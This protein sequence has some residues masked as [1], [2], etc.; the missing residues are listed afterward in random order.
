MREKRKMPGVPEAGVFLVILASVLYV[1]LLAGGNPEAFLIDDNRTQWYPVMERAY[2]DLW[3]AGRIYCYD[4]YQMKGMSVAGQGYYGIMNPFI[5]LSYSVTK[6]LPEGIDAI[7]FYI[8]MMVVLGNLFLYLVCRRLG[9]KE[10]AALLLTLAYS[11]MGC[12]WA[13]YIWYYVFNNYFLVPLLVYVFLRCRQE[14]R[15]SYC[16]CGVVL[17]MDLWMGNVQYTFYHYILF[18]ILCLTMAAL[19]NRCYFKILCINTTV[20]IVLSLPM[21]L[22]LLQTSGGFQKHEDFMSYPLLY[23]S[24]LIH[25][26]IPQGILRCRGGGVNFL[27]AFVM[28][29]DDN[30]VCYMGIVGILLATALFRAVVRLLKRAGESGQPRELWEA[31]RTGYERAVLWTHEKKTAAGCAAA[32]LFFLSLMSGGAAAHCLS[33]MPVVRNFRYLF[34]A[35]FPAMPLAVLMLAHIIGRD[36]RK[37]RLRSATTLFVLAAVYA[38]VGVLNACDTVKFVRHLYDMRLEKDFAGEKEAAF[39]ALAAADV[40][41]KNYRTAAFLRFSGL[42]DECFDMSRNLTRNFPTAVGV[43]SL[44][45]YEIATEE[46]RLGM[47]DAIYSETEFLTRYAN[48]DTLENFNLNLLREP[49]KVQRQLVENSVRY[50]FLDKTTLAENRLAQER[51]DCRFQ[52]DRREEVIAALRALPDIRV[53][54]IRPFNEHYDLAELAGTASLCMDKAGHKV[55]LTDE[56]MQTLSFDAQAAQDYTLSFAWDRH[57]KAFLTEADGAIRPLSVEETENGNIRIS[58]AGSGGRVTLTWRDPLCTAGFVWEGAS[59]GLFFGMLATLA[60]SRRKC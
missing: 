45:G 23:F 9:C 52:K 37:R 20:G 56:N 26:V 12:F 30:L 32:L 60:F 8:G 17:A 55:P 25:S 1:V 10:P 40:D 43:F 42:N 16:A 31:C 47:F 33:V 39:S 14:E 54:R 53:E 6:L 57:L 24:L 4:F 19:K 59:A 50:L 41:G 7:T 28:G 49:E 29:R 3:T 11:T 18:G 13:F 38:S 44:A 35:V 5:L 46:S 34:K 21:L 2:E 51:E 36:S 15:F 58:T 48:A 22:L 27:D